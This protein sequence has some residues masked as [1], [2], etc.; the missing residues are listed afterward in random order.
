VDFD[1][2]DDTGTIL[3]YDGIRYRFFRVD[4]PTERV[5]S[6]GE[7][8]NFRPGAT[9]ASAISKVPAFSPVQPRLTLFGLYFRGAGRID[10]RTYLLGSVLPLLLLSLADWATT[11][12]ID[13]NTDLM[14]LL[15]AVSTPAALYWAGFWLVVSLVLS[16]APLAM[17]L[18]DRDRSGWFTLIGLVPVVGWLW[19]LIDACLLPGTPGPNRHGMAPLRFGR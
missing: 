17:R 10:R 6:V 18:H 2:R 12:P 1:P 9:M 16:V 14:A 19:L 15:D 7:E 5:P 3:G 4:W 13:E 11:P 8:V